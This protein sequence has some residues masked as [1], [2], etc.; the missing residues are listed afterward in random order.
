MQ[1]EE[2]PGRLQNYWY[3]QQEFVTGSKEGLKNWYK[4][5]NQ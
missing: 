5:Q 4:M 3:I 2:D 1:M